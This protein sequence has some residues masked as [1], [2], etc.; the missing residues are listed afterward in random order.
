M[1]RAMRNLR[2]QSCCFGLWN[3]TVTSGVCL[4]THQNGTTQNEKPLDRYVLCTVHGVL[5]LQGATHSRIT[6]FQLKRNNSAY[7]HT[8][9]WAVVLD[10][11]W[12]LRCKILIAFN[13][14]KK[15][16]A[17]YFQLHDLH[18]SGRCSIRCSDLSEGV[19]IAASRVCWCEVFL[20]MSRLLITDVPACKSPVWYHSRWSYFRSFVVTTA[21]VLFVGILVVFSKIHSFVR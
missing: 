18:L 12:T 17:S 3:V 20:T 19:V 2:W 4:Y 8:P 16:A 15:Y 7:L 11:V 9:R 1:E 13:D 6:L 21:E 14:S 5:F 10:K